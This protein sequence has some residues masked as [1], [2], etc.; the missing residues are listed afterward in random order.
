MRFVIVGGDAAGMSAASRA[1]RR[2][3]EM[4]I[5]VL[6][7]S[8]D[9]S[10]SACGMPYNI[11]DPGCDMSVLVVRE[12][13]IFREKQ[14]IDVRLGHRAER[15]DPAARTVTGRAEDGTPFTLSYDHLLLA[16]GARAIMPDLPG[17]DLPGVFSLKSLEDGRCIKAFLGQQPVSRAV[18][19]GM[20]YIALEMTEALRTRG[21]E[22]AMVKPGP[23][24]LPWL[25]RALVPPLAAELETHDVVVHLGH[26]AER[27]EQ[28]PTGLELVAGEL[29]LGAD[30]VLSAVGVQPNSELAR[31][32][33]LSLGPGGAI[34]VDRVGRTSDPNI[35]AAGDCAT[36]YH[37]VTGRPAWI[38]LAL[39]ANRAGWAVA[40][41]ICG[42]PTVL[43]G[44]AGTTVFKLFDLE[45]ARSGLT[46]RE[47]TEAGFHPV[48]ESIITRSKAHGQPGAGE[49][50]AHVVGDDASGRLLGAQL[51]GPP[52]SSVHRIFA[53]AVALLAQLSV[54]Q[55][56]Q[57]DLAYAPPF[58]PVWDPLLTASNQLQRK[59]SCT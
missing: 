7:Q 18:I 1:K 2:R 15:I 37:V 38:P 42:S 36:A 56:A 5:I 52:G 46:A 35:H 28:T 12:A 3:P 19:L 48:T 47:A 58:G 30:I 53:V 54:A 33:G 39:I 22:V 55:F 59:L 25:D 49:I 20:G 13:E 4:E 24:F 50:H 43:E 44:I 32:A 23:E 26:C 34:L 31:D 6:E 27:I 9:V 40:D 57:A 21:I 14:G 16:T 41:D 17:F 8:R 11:A 51:V 29:R 45:I 10:Y